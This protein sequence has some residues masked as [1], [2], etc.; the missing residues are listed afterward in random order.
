MR[1]NGPRSPTRNGHLLAPAGRSGLTTGP[2]TCTSTAMSTAAWLCSSTGYQIGCTA[3]ASGLV[4]MGAA[5][6]LGPRVEH[7]DGPRPPGRLAHVLLGGERPDLPVAVHL[8]AQAPVGDPPRLA[9]AVLPPPLRPGRARSRVAVL[10][11]GERFLQRPGT[12]VQ[13]DVRLG[14]EL[15]AVGQVL[16]GAEPV[17]F[18][19]AP[20]QL[21]AAR[22]AVD[23]PDPVGPV[24]VADEVP[25]R[26][27]Q[28]PEPQLAEQAEHVL[29]EAAV[30]GQ[31][32]A[33][34]VQ[35]AVDAPSEVLDEPAEHLPVEPPDGPG[36]INGD[37]GQWRSFVVG[38]FRPPQESRT[39]S[40]TGSSGVRSGTG[41]PAMLRRSNST[42][43]RPVSASGMRT[44]LS[45]GVRN[46]A[47]GMSSQLTTATS[48][49]TL[50]P[51]CHS[52]DSTPMAITSLCTKIAVS[53][54]E[55]SSSSRV[56]TAPPCGV[57][58][59][60]A[61]RSSLGSSPASRSASS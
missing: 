52:A 25:A 51:A 40:S 12:H 18:L 19:P 27:A 7:P 28:H 36:R 56:A 24:V 32:R 45:G 43:C 20:G 21:G 5:D 59:P 11:P 44:V 48:A 1:P 2:F 34:V 53:P 26:P 41:S 3:A 14:A 39:I 46:S 10:D 9:P 58:S 49:G 54:G 30:V 22:P 6:Q 38:M 13:A 47:N 42:A 37:P 57:Q 4:T 55:R 29:A 31:R 16:V 17:G 8:V 35:P 15:G 23:G 50:R 60:S 33:P 61:T